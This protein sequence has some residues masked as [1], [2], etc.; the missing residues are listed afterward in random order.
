MVDV[1]VLWLHQGTLGAGVE[2]DADG[3]CFVA[4]GVVGAADEGL[5]GA[6]G[7]LEVGVGPLS[8]HNLLTVGMIIVVLVINHLFS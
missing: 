7:L 4:G 1:H 3:V 6:V 5:V 2:L 8:A